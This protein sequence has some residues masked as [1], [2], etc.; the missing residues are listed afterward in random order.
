MKGSLGGFGD[1]CCLQ[2]I[3]CKGLLCSFLH[4]NVKDKSSGIVTS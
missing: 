3:N 4:R 1:C 2:S